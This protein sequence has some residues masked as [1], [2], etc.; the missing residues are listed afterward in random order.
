MSKPTNDDHVPSKV[1]L[2][3]PFPANIHVVETCAECNSGFS[4]DEEYFAAFLGSVMSGSTDPEAQVFGASRKILTRN[5][6]QVR[7]ALGMSL[8]TAALMSL[9]G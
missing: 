8:A 6:A 1:L 5:A 2:D 9:P 7:P 3:R 4:A